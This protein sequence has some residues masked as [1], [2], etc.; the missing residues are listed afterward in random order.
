[1]AKAKIEYS[2]ILQRLWSDP[3][4]S[5]L[6]SAGFLSIIATI[7][8]LLDNLDGFDLKP[9]DIYFLGFSQGAC[10]VLEYCARHA[11]QYGGIIAFTG[12]LIGQEPD[13]SRYKGSFEGTPVFI[14]SSDNDPH[15]PESRIRQ[16][17]V[18][19]DRMGAKVIK[20]IYP[21]ME[22]TVNADEWMMAGLILDEKITNHS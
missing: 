5:Q 17:E 22:H 8:E 9:K 11:R 13:I 10:L 6:F 12:G 20:K 14:G 19:L 1:M 3:V 16:T 18:I 4:F 7:S 2:G 15:V 21:R